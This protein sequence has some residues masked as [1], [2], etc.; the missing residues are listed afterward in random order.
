VAN[1][2][3]VGFESAKLEG[4]RFGVFGV[5]EASAKNIPP[6]IEKHLDEKGIYHKNLQKK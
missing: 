4:A 3:G 1:L 6:E 5:G 2:E